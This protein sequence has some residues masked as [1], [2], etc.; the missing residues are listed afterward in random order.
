MQAQV[1]FL[2]I[3]LWKE[4]KRADNPSEPNFCDIRPLRL[5][6]LKSLQRLKI[7]SARADDRPH[8]DDVLRKELT[9][10]ALIL[11]SSTSPI[12]VRSVI[13]E[14]SFLEQCQQSPSILMPDKWLSI[15]AILASS[16]F[17]ELHTVEVTVK[18]Y[19]HPGSEM[20]Q[21][22]IDFMDL[23]PTISSQSWISLMTST[24]QGARRHTAIY[25]MYPYEL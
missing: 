21:R 1:M 6:P 4:Y 18:G 14:T 16:I 2:S 9:L 17:L 13:L 3:S 22:R 25:E 5:G 23:L 10:M 15:D 19:P 7:T 12:H 20:Q 24:T 11:A 8:F